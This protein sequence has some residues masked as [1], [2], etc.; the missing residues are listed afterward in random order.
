MTVLTKNMT[1][2]EFR[3]LEFDDDDN[4]QYEL[5]NG[6]LV[7]KASP[8]VQHQRISMRL[9]AAFLQHLHANPIGE[10]FHAP[11]DV[12]LDDYNAPQPDIIFIRNENIGIINEQEQV[13]MGAP[14]ILIEIISPG[15]IKRDRIE[16]KDLYE[17][18]AVPEFWIIDPNNQSI[19]VYQ[20]QEGH[21]QIFSFAASEG[22]VQSAVLAGFELDVA[23]IFN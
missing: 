3:T 20:L 22:A 15:S 17:K 16:K 6:E 21:Y 1:Y 8:T 12:V 9:L 5:L 10:I 23:G 18:F 13:V 2:A 19:E 11:L 14:D 7:K 4:F